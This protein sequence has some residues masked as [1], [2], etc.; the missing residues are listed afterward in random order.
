MQNK[1]VIRQATEADLPQMLEIYNDVVVNTT[2][3]W[4]YTPHTLEMRQIWFAEKQ[5]LGYPVFLAIS[6]DKIVGFSTFGQ[7]RPW[8]GY[9]FTAENSVYVKSDCRGKG[10]GKLLLPPLIDAARNLKLHTL[11]AGIDAS[12]EA[13]I[14][15]HKKFGFEEV[16]YFKQVGYKFH[17]WLDLIFLELIL[18]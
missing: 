16:A 11:V 4:D 2:A 1:I 10:I 6:E 12:N 15:L 13:S 9:R 14:H 18:E 7:F 8:A 5:K 17:R 3:V